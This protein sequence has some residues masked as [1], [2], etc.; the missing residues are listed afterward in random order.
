MV[1]QEKYHESLTG[2]AR[3]PVWLSYAI[4]I[5]GFAAVLGIVPATLLLIIYD[6]QLVLGIVVIALMVAIIVVS[7]TVPP[8]VELR[9]RVT[10]LPFERPMRI[11]D[12]VLT[13]T[14][15]A[16]ATARDTMLI[17]IELDDGQRWQL[18]DKKTEVR[19]GDVVTG[20]YLARD[21]LVRNL[22]TVSSE[23]S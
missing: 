21:S 13:H 2:I 6:S 18:F 3:M 10:W 23:F 4:S 22:K 14:A 8:I 12:V 5:C 1:A 19:M 9:R 11:V 20:E 17:E 16:M 15:H 7:M